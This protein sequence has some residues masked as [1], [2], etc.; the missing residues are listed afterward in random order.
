MDAELLAD[1]LA[2]WLAERPRYLAVAT[3]VRAL[4]LD[5]RLPLGT[6][7]PTERELAA[8]LGASRSTI[9]AAYDRLRDAGW[10][11]SGGR[12]G[13]VAA[14]PA[15]APTRGD[16]VGGGPVGWD[17]SVAALPAPSQLVDAVAAAAEA[18]QRHLGGPGLHPAGLPELRQAVADHLSGRGLPTSPDQVLITSGA[19]HAWTLVLGALA[20]TGDRVLVEQPTY[21]GVLDA[22][23]A[24]RLRP[25]P[26]AVGP[27]VGRHGWDLDAAGPARLALVTPDGQ[28]P[29]GLLAG[30]GARQQLLGALT[31]AGVAWICCDETFADLVLDGAAPTPLGAMSEAVLTIGS[32]SKAFWAGLRVGWVR[33]SPHVLALLSGQRA[34]TDLASPVLEQLVA[35]ELLG[36]AGEVLAD[37]RALLRANRAA[38]VAALVDRLGWGVEAPAAGMALWPS[39]GHPGATLLASAALELGLRLVPGPRFTTDGSADHRLRLPLSV[40]A[41]R[42]GELARLLDAARERAVLARLSRRDLPAPARWTA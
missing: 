15:P 20:R 25:S 42:A 39:V 12:A 33:A 29:T 1:L 31:D 32:M 41:A 30:V 34:A 36:R 9:S 3:G 21:P 38:L 16:P 14:H 2:P 22:L 19:L 23:A 6:R 18:L 26:L 10:A 27:G 8:V 28:N 40:P 11:R 5:G 17:L 37:R 35:A 13:T 7:L 24:R 4:I